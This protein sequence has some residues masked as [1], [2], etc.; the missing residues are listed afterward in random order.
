MATSSGLAGAV[1]SRAPTAYDQQYMDRLVDTLNKLIE[2]VVKPQ[3]ITAA[4]LVLTGLAQETPRYDREGEVYTKVCTGC[5]CTVLAIDQTL[6]E[7]LTR[8]QR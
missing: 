7:N 4:S 3:Q 8:R 6:A 5:G 1:I 2:Q